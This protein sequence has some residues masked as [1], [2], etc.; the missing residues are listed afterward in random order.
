MCLLQH[1]ESTILHSCM[2]GIG[3]YEETTRRLLLSGAGRMPGGGGDLLSASIVDGQEAE[4]PEMMTRYIGRFSTPAFKVGSGKIA[5]CWRTFSEIEPLILTAS[6]ILRVRVT[7]TLN[8]VKFVCSIS[9][10]SL[11]FS[12]H[13]STDRRAVPSKA[14]GFRVVVRGR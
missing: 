2:D 6:P 12:T 11:P 9:L 10:P 5:L 8:P 4:A 7:K 3:S 14:M 1:W 13:R